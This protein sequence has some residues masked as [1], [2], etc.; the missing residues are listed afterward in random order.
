MNKILA[1]KVNDKII[2]AACAF[3]DAEA[4]KEKYLAHA[5]TILKRSDGVCSI[6][7]ESLGSDKA[8]F[9]ISRWTHF[10]HC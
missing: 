2:C 4:N 8:R 7:G 10:L 6:C 3:V 5:K 9:F 1:F